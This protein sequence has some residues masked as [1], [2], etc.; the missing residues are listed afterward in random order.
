M[1]KSIGR[2]IIALSAY[3]LISACS[4]TSTPVPGAAAVPATVTGMSFSST[5]APTDQ[6]ALAAPNAAMNMSIPYT[7]TVVTVTFSD[8]SQS[9]YP[10]EHKM[11][12]RSD[13]VIQTGAHAG[14][15]YGGVID[16]AGAPV[17]D[18][19]AANNPFYATVT[20]AAVAAGL[21]LANK[22]QFVS[23]TPDGTALIQIPGAP[24]SA[25]TADLSFL[26]HFEYVTWDG[27]RTSQYGKNPGFIGNS[28]VSQD[29][30]T[31][32]LSMKRFDKQSFAA[33]KGL[34]IP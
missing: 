19:V 11:L 30:T 29:L 24:S 8:G 22:N 16:Q 27:N 18:P 6:Y 32:L 7:T 25:T 15:Y 13:D 10:L 20:G 17:L 34:W 31:G 5:L 28:T 12:F 3:T 4:Q 9:Q 21:A 23:D 33:G 26:N 2:M 1:S 14:E